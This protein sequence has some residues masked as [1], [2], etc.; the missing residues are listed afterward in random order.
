MILHSDDGNSSRGEKRGKKI[1]Q[2]NAPQTVNRPVTC[3]LVVEAKV[4]L[5]V[6]AA[7]YLV[8]NERLRFAL[9]VIFISLFVVAVPVL[10]DAKPSE[11][12]AATGAHAAVLVVFV[13]GDLSRGDPK[14]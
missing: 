13:S 2:H 14:S 10:D 6:L 5:D 7:L 3:V 4:L 1:P 9:V 12:F 11:M 8:A